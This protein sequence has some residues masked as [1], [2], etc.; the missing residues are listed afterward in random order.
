MS[1]F[2]TSRVLRRT[3][4]PLISETTITDGD[5]HRVGITW[6]GSNRIL[7]VDDT[8]V[9]QDTQP[10]L[11]KASDSL[12]IGTGRN[13]ATGSFWSGLIDDVQIYDR[14]VTP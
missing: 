3:S 5:W 4:G 9:A 1:S 11:P 6:D 10:N 12:Q 14:V 2:D 13:Q 8:A 7:Y